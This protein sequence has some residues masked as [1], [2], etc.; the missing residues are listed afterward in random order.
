[1]TV[2][3]WSTNVT[4]IDVTAQV[5]SDI[6]LTPMNSGGIASCI[7]P[8]LCTSNT[9]GRMM[10]LQFVCKPNKL[11]EKYSWAWQQFYCLSASRGS[12]YVRGR[13][14]GFL[15]PLTFTGQ[16]IP[17]R[18]M[19]LHIFALTYIHLRLHRWHRILY[20]DR[21]CLLLECGR[22]LCD[23]SLYTDRII[24]LTSIG[25]HDNN[26]TVWGNLE[27]AVGLRIFDMQPF[28]LTATDWSTHVAEEDVTAQISSDI[29]SF[30]VTS[31]DMESHILADTVFLAHVTESDVGAQVPSDIFPS[32]VTSGDIESCKDRQC[33]FHNWGC[34]W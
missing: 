27:L 24:C 11:L 25:D 17:L 7:W 34:A 16:P 31:G 8:T 32:P 3:D 6:H 30:P 19:C 28:I 12:V 2:I 4:E 10:Y 5:S 29:H 20:F 33:V 9:K 13:W 15:F 14:H 26:S 21:H 22:G 1:M 23:C 18:M